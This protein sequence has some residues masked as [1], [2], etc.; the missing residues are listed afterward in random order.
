L[1]LL[2]YGLILLAPFAGAWR[3]QGSQRAPALYLALVA[4]VGYAGMGLT[5][6]MFGVLAQTLVYTVLLSL[7]AVLA[8][9]PKESFP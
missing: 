8:G 3:A 6:A 2:S 9:R 7:V 4:S 5:N 1:G